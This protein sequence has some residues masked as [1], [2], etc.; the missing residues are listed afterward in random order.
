MGIAIA[1]VYAI[2]V[3]VIN[4]KTGW[5]ALAILPVLAVALVLFLAGSF[6]GW[7]WGRS[8]RGKTMN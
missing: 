5:L 2:Y 8:R 3:V 7:L 6:V 4:L 1:L